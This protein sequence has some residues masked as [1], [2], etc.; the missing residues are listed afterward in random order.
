MF[1]RE[2]FSY[3]LL[4]DRKNER[5]K[6]GSGKDSVLVRF[7]SLCAYTLNP[8]RPSSSTYASVQVRRVFLV[9]STPV[10]A[11]LRRLKFL[12]RN[13]YPCARCHLANPLNYGA[14]RVF[15][16]PLR[17]VAFYPFPFTPSSQPRFTARTL[18]NFPLRSISRN[19]FCRS[20]SAPP[21][22][23]DKPG[24]NSF[25]T[26]TRRLFMARPHGTPDPIDYVKRT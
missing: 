3:S 18:E 12:P 8:G 16:P 17:H 7:P 22:T 6:A 19:N 5:E 23:T 14:N 24:N 4:Y 1:R 11:I 21:R 2:Y 13:R 20:E 15:P 9:Y 26:R 10:K 25:C